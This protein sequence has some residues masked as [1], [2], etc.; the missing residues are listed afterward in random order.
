MMHEMKVASLLEVAVLVILV[1]AVTLP[2]TWRR[3]CW[4]SQGVRRR[5]CGSTCQA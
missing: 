2:L 4:I 3:E 1:L 5:Y